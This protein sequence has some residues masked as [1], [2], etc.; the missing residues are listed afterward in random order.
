MFNFISKNQFIFNYRRMWPFIKP[1]WFR[2]LLGILLTIPAG[3]LD[4]VIAAFLKPIT[5]NVLVAKDVEFSRALPFIIIGFTLLQSVLNYAATYVNAWVGSKISLGLK[6]HLYDK[7][8]SMDPIYFDQRSSGEIIL[9]YSNDAELATG[10]LVANLKLFLTKFF[11]SLGLVGVMLYNSWQLSII[12]LG[13]FVLAVYPVKLVKRKIKDVTTKTVGATA[14]FLTIYNETFSGNKIINSFTLEETFRGKFD[15]TLKFLFR[16]SIKLTQGGG[17]LSPLLHF[18]GSLG[19]ALVLGLG[20]N[21]IVT[22]TITPGNFIAFIGAMMMLYTPLK[23]IGTNYVKVQM[24]FLAI[25]RIFDILNAEPKIKSHD[26]A[27]TLETI[28]EGLECRKVFFSYVP[29]RPVLRDVSLKISVGQTVAL[30]GNS[31]GGKTTIGSLLPRLYE[32]DRGEILIDGVN[33]KDY[34]LESLRRNIA[35][36]F[37]DNFL[38]SGTIRDN[39]QMGNPE[40]TEEDM[41]QALA[42]ANLDQFIKTSE[43]GLDTVVGERGILL[44]G[45]QKQRVAIARAFIKNAPLVIL[46]EATSALDNKAEKVVQEALEKL[47]KDRTVI[48]I[49]HR[50]ST[51]QSAD[52]ILVVNDGRIVEQGNHEELMARQGAY[53][54]LYATRFVDGQD[55][56]SPTDESNSHT[57]DAPPQAMNAE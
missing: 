8:L 55:Q 30:V 14:N 38:F 23:S 29:E 35:I 10:G 5:D 11:S 32:V 6:W 37:Q 53:Y 49:A 22:E 1:Y 43:K 24:S 20:T 56:D 33:I 40:A 57:S 27:V 19:L 47:M 17:W 16:L 12:A 51:I 52:N 31:G 45:G 44:S 18:I 39:L 48:V 26:G 54:A 42:A 46:D 7:L 34:T 21:L 15:Q 3:S 13:I 36:V 41:W 9:R 25:D 28:R 2:A 50:L 4:A